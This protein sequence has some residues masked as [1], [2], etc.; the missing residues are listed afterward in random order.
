MSDNENGNNTDSFEQTLMLKRDSIL[1][2]IRS[3]DSSVT[4]VQEELARKIEEL[5]STR[6]TYEETLSH[7]QALLEIETNGLPPIESL[8]E[9]EGGTFQFLHTALQ[10]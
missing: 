1:D 8:L 6:S 5:H 4:E 2:Q 3:I 9:Q 10:R 7:I